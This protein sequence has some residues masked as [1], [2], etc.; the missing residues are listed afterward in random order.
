MSSFL[1][2]VLD[3]QLPIAK[4]VKKPWFKKIWM[5]LTMRQISHKD[6][7]AR[8]PQLGG[9][10]ISITFE[11]LRFLGYE[12]GISKQQEKFRELL[13]RAEIPF[14]QIA[15]NDPNVDDDVKKEGLQL[16]DYNRQQ[17]KWI[18]MH[19]DDFKDSL[20]MLN[21]KRAKE[22]R[23]YYRNLESAVFKFMHH[24]LDVE[25]HKIEEKDAQLALLNDDLTESGK[26]SQMAHLTEKF[27]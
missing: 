16:S 11:I 8:S 9:P 26:M 14:K 2:F 4:D 18:T 7:A 10:I 22:I 19:I 5:P 13:D 3:N 27:C 15:F 23:L 6:E 21:T 17:K 12:G 20:M 1:Q 25:R 24:S